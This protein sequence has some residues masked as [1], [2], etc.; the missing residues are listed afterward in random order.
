MSYSIEELENLIINLSSNK[1]LT[2]F[3]LNKLYT[4]VLEEGK[5]A[6]YTDNYNVDASINI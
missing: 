3:Y 1:D 2:K 5:Y 4:E 6:A